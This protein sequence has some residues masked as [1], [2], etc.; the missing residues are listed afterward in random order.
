M[1]LD[2]DSMAV[3]A[4]KTLSMGSFNDEEWCISKREWYWL[5]EIEVAIREA[6]QSVPDYA[7]AHADFLS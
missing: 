4:G 1:Y 7:G 2:K 5:Q 3:I 6:K